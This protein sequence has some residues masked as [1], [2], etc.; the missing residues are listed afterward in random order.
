MLLIYIKLK[1]RIRT[2]QRTERYSVRKIMRV[3]SHIYKTLFVVGIMQN[4]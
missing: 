3:I 4:V 1:Y 2:A